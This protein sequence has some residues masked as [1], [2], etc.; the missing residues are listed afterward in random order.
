MKKLLTLALMAL[1]FITA[2]GDSESPERTC[3]Y[4][5]VGPCTQKEQGG[6]QW[7]L[8]SEPEDQ[9]FSPQ[10]KLILQ[11]FGF[12]TCDECYGGSYTTEHPEYCRQFDLERS[13][14]QCK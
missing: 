6:P 4:Q 8:E 11:Q 3:V 9:N 12:R 14:D 2:C 5:L 10:E 7:W 1:A 13:G